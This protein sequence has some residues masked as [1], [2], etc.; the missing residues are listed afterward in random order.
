MGGTILPPIGFSELLGALFGVLIG[1]LLTI[2][3]DRTKRRADE[4]T[5]RQRT[6]RAIAGELREISRDLE[7]LDDDPDTQPDFSYPTAAYRSSIASGRFSLLDEAY[8][9]DIAQ[10]YE[11]ISQARDVQERFQQI[12][13]RGDRSDREYRRQLRL[14][15]ND[16]VKTLQNELPELIDRIETHSRERGGARW[17]V[18]QWSVEQLRRP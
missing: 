14:Q 11:R 10:M 17:T 15:F 1:Q 8:Q 2:W 7:R 3:W 13:L 9:L 4:R 16:Y 5:R 18:G 12:R 6:A